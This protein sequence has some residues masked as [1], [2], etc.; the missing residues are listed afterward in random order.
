MDKR[1]QAAQALA[2]ARRS[3]YSDPHSSNIGGW[4]WR[5]LSDVTADL[6]NMTEIPSHVQNFGQFMDETA[7]K[8]KNQGLSARDLVKAYTITLS[9]IQRQA[10]ATEKLRQKGMAVPNAGPMIRPEGAFGEWLHTPGG[11]A[12]LDAAVKGQVHEG[13]LDDMAQKFGHYGLVNRMKDGMR[14]AAQNLPGK[15]KQVSELVAAGLEK[16]ST[17]ADWRAFAKGLHGIDTSKAGFVASMLGRGDQPTFDARQRIIHTGL[18]SNEAGKMISGQKMNPKAQDALDRLAARQEAMGL[19]LPENLQPYYQ[20]LA[21]HAVWDQ[22]EGDQT[23]HQDV[24]DSMRHAASGGA[25]DKAHP[26]NHP[27]AHAMRALGFHGLIQKAGGG[28]VDEEDAEAADTIKGLQSGSISSEEAIQR[29]LQRVGDVTSSDPI[30]SQHARDVAETMRTKMGG[31]TGTGSYYGVK[32]SVNPLGV[33]TKIKA[34]A[35]RPLK[36]RQQGSWQN[37]YDSAKG[38]TLLNLGGDRSNFGTLTHINDR[39]L[40]WPV[41]LYAGPKYMLEPNPGEV[42]ANNLNHATAIKNKVQEAAK[43]GDVYGGYAPMGQTGSD[44]AHHMFDALMAQVPINDIKPEDAALFDQY[45]KSGAHITGNSPKDVKLRNKAKEYLENWPGLMNAKKASN[46]ALSLPGNQ[47]AAIVKGMD[48]SM[49][50]DK[51]FPEVG[52]TRVAITDPDVLD[53]PGN[54]IGHRIAKLNPDEMIKAAEKRMKHP[55][56]ETPTFGE[57][58]MDVPLLPRQDVLVDPTRRMMSEPTKAG[59]IVHPYSLDALGRS[60]YRKLTEEQK[61]LQPINDEMMESINKAQLRRKIYGLKT[62]GRA[63][64][65]GSDAVQKAVQIARQHTPGRR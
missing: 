35:G 32:Q 61:Q 19:A 46:F 34:M 42:W 1:E 18:T 55:T 40:A 8:A 20:H 54:M 36:Q 41:K 23:T 39:Q 11:Q 43:K 24:M 27:L 12:Y 2:I 64:K 53:A 28:E 52:V 65:S 57:Y 49:W 29:A 47:R 38:G 33:T 16:A 13:A 26:A 21:H 30:L 63:T 31:E 22:A 5:P 4:N 3:Q 17:P 56:Y 9:S 10:Q 59:Q 14:W 50:R 58:H 45:I 48:K 15:E 51:G 62:G 7:K 25:I 37:F 6:G 60:T 44:A